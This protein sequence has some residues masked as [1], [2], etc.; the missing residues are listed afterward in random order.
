[1][2]ERD[3]YPIGVP[4]WVDTVQP[5]PQAAARFYGPLFGWEFEGPGDYLE[6]RV[7][8]R[9]VAGIAQAPDTVPTAVWTTYVRVDDVEDAL[10]RAGVAGGATFMGPL[11]AAPAGRLG[12]LSDPGG[13]VLGVWQPGGRAGAQLVNE[14]GSWTMS[15]LHT[16]DPERAEAF[17]GA[18]FGWRLEPMAGAPIS[19]WRLP[20]YVGG[21][22][23]QPV[24]RDVV[25]V[26]TPTDDA[27]AV[28]PH[29]AVDFWVEDADAIAQHA[30]ALGGTVLMPPTDTPGFRNAVIADPQGGVVAISAL[31][32]AH[33]QR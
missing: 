16:D 9:L 25:A 15:A 2:A 27:A 17:Y 20:G 13:V 29:W 5:D 1:M 26:M 3:H 7:R 4:C 8:G 22:P 19:L 21:E 6:A 24:P 30:A 31:A 28:P 33:A 18:V 11:D 12:L 23:Q 10:G 32:T 14:P